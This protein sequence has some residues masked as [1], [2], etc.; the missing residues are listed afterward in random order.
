V[1]GEG[2]PGRGGQVG[3]A[4]LSSEVLQEVVGHGVAEDL[5]ALGIEELDEGCGRFVLGPVGGADFF[6]CPR[7]QVSSGCK[8]LR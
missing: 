3:A 1:F 5:A 7:D 2:L 4:P 6:Q 8:V